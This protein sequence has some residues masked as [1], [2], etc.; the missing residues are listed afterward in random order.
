MRAAE[1]RWRSLDFFARQGHAIRASSSLVPGEDPTLLF[2]NAGMVQFK[3]VFL[4]QEQPPGGN[5][6]LNLLSAG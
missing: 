1:T 6:R 3:K 4:G 5:R 2:T